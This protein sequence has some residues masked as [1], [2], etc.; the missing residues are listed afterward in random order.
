MKSVDR[1]IKEHD[2][3]ERGLDLLEKSV[4]LSQSGQPMRSWRQMRLGGR[5]GKTTAHNRK[6]ASIQP[7]L[8]H[9]NN[10]RKGHDEYQFV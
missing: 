6:W 5:G 2:L 10:S 9:S 4:A 1:L 7:P 3:I 8:N